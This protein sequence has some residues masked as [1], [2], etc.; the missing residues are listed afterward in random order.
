MG[1]VLAA[2]AIGAVAGPNLLGPAG[3]LAR[4]AG[5]HHVAGLYLVAI[6]SFGLAA[7]L[8]ARRNGT[9]TGDRGAGRIVHFRMRLLSPTTGRA[10]IIL[11]AAN[12][13]MVATM[14]IAPVHM[15]EHGHGL[16]LVGTVVSI[17]VVCMFAP[18]PLWG[19][20]G[21]VAGHHVVVTIG[22]GLVILAGIAGATS[23][24]TQAGAMTGVLAL[25][26]LGWSAGVVGAS[27]VLAGSVPTSARPRVEGI[28]EVAMSL[29]AGGGAPLAGIVVASGG[30]TTLGLAAAVVGACALAVGLAERG[31]HSANRSGRVSLIDTE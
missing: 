7:I 29:A 26:G 23:N 2:A 13:A 11:G 28:G 4:A 19:W 25:L 20:L 22:A 18:A 5:L 8:L 3:A 31:I 1:L 30:F 21:D 14:A 15:V 24:T 17:H 16:T 12:L 27:A 10:L 9:A 6:P